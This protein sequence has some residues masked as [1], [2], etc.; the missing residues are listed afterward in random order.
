MTITLEE[1]YKQ[2]RDKRLN[3]K[4]LG[5]YLDKNKTADYISHGDK[6]IAEGTPVNRP[7]PDGGHVKIAIFGAGFGGLCAASRALTEGSAS[8]P[9]DLVIIDRGRGFGGTWWHNR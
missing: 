2:E 4:G 3:D 6:W 8:S 1:R 5:Q 9:D 7:V